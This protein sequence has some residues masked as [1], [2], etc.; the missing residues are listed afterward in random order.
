MITPLYD[1]IFFVG[2]CKK[3]IKVKSDLLMVIMLLV[4]NPYYNLSLTIVPSFESD[5]KKD[6][7]LPELP[8]VLF[9]HSMHCSRWPMLWQQLAARKIKLFV[10]SRKE[11][12][13]L[14]TSS[15]TQIFAPFQPFSTYRIPAYLP[16]F[17]PLAL[18]VSLHICKCCY[19]P[20]CILEYL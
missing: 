3:I 11:K 2:L 5:K 19:E 13:I 9:V 17:N 15:G 12:G 1:C 18:S 8:Q 16:P 4:Y 20:F 6:K 10:F 14:C 7:P